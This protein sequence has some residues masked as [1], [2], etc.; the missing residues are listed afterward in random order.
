MRHR[1]LRFDRW[2][3]WDALAEPKGMG[4]L[5]AHYALV[6]FTKGWPQRPAVRLGVAP[7]ELCR[8]AACVASRPTRRR[9]E[10][11]D[12]W[13]DVPRL[14]H[15]ARRDGDHPCQLPRLLVE[16]LVA[17]TTHPGGVVL[18]AFCGTGTTGA[19]AL[20]LARRSVL[21]DLSAEYVEVAARRLRGAR[22][23]ARGASQTKRAL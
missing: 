2:I 12:V 13:H 4:L 15:A 19:A 8:R 6:L 9:V 16:R 1:A 5:P 21:G 14:R 22:H 23:E 10:A 20:A 7:R 3:V 11:T 17:L 18:D